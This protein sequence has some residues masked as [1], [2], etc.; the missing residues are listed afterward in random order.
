MLSLET[1]MEMYP[2]LYQMCMVQEF[3]L[4]VE[5]CLLILEN[6]KSLEELSHLRLTLRCSQEWM[7]KRLIWHGYLISNQII[8][9]TQTYPPM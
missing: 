9:N 3:Y 5:H 6:L 4:I 1:R 8:C 2:R 7:E